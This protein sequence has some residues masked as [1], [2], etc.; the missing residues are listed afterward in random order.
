MVDDRVEG[1]VFVLK[2]SLRRLHVVSAMVALNK[3]LKFTIHNGAMSQCAFLTWESKSYN[4]KHQKID[5]E[6][7]A[8]AFEKN[9]ANSYFKNPLEQQYCSDTFK[10]L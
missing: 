8:F 5:T 7:G 4:Y 2:V 6:E 1:H 10:Q 3:T 9:K